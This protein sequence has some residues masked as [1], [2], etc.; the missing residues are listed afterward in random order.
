VSLPGPSNG[1]EGGEASAAFPKA[2]VRVEPG[3]AYEFSFDV[4]C[5]GLYVT[6]LITLHFTGTGVSN[7]GVTSVAAN[8]VC[9]VTWRRLR[10]ELTVPEG[11]TGLYPEFGFTFTGDFA[12]ARYVELDRLALVPLLR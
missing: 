2:T 5:S 8:V 1:R 9:D 3:R 7:L 4:L 11:A 10:A 6:P 12:Y